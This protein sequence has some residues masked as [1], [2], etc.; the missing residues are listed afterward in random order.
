MVG[1][2]VGEGWMDD[3]SMPYAARSY[4]CIERRA[5]NSTSLS[6]R[7]V[8]L[9]FVLVDVA[10]LSISDETLEILLTCVLVS[11][12]LVPIAVG[13]S[14]VNVRSAKSARSEDPGLQPSS[15]PVSNSIF[16]EVWPICLVDMLWLRATLSYSGPASSYEKAS[17]LE[18]WQARQLALTA[19]QNFRASSS[20]LFVGDSA[21]SRLGRQTAGHTLDASQVFDSF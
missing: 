21:D 10:L 8:V 13:Y 18:L 2:A 1:W 11:S 12:D 7:G 15:L 17:D 16:E 19:R 6:S 5:V 20:C 9:L 3:E 4:R 14:G